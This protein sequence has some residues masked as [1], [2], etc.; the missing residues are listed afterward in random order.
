MEKHVHVIQCFFSII[1]KSKLFYKYG[2]S[3][4]AYLLLLMLTKVLFKFHDGMTFF[5]KCK[6]N[7]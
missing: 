2:Y 1:L 7:I 6:I 3:L 4:L 5:V